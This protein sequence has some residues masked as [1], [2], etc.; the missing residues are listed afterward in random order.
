MSG[1]PSPHLRFSCVV[2]ALAACDGDDEAPR[3][4]AAPTELTVALVGAGGHLTWTDNSDDEDEFVIMRARDDGDLEE[5]ARTAFDTATYHD[6]PLES[7][8]TYTYVVH[9]ENADGQSDPSNEAMLT[10]P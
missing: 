1:M 6:E 9:A 8:A 10:V 3:V 4:P 7:G 2:L 5:V